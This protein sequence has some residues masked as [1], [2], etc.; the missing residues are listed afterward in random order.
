M[1]SFLKLHVQRT[2]ENWWM[3]ERTSFFQKMKY[4]VSE[5]RVL[6]ARQV[7]HVFSSYKYCSMSFVTK[8]WQFYYC[9]CKI[10]YQWHFCKVW[11]WKV[12]GWHYCIYWQ[13]LSLPGAYAFNV[14]L[15][16]VNVWAFLGF[17]IFRRKPDSN[18]YGGYMIWLIDSVVNV[19]CLCTVFVEDCWTA[20]W[21]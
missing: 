16:A 4:I 19:V 12:S 7:I 17:P 9:F 8:T 11:R 3:Q 21:K 2:I 15:I 6:L 13:I 18:C 1:R 10:F 14:N 20:D 5:C